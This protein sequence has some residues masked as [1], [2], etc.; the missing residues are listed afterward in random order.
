MAHKWLYIL[1]TH[2]FT[3]EDNPEE[4]LNLIKENFSKLHSNDTIQLVIIKN[5]FSKLRGVTNSESK[6]LGNSKTNISFCKTSL[7]IGEKNET[8]SVKISPLKKAFNYWQ[9]AFDYVLKEYKADNY[10]LYTYSHSDGF[11][12][13]LTEKCFVLNSSGNLLNKKNNIPA[14]QS[15]SF[16]R[17]FNFII[18]S[19][20]IK[21]FFKGF[22][23]NISFKKK[24]YE[25]LQPVKLH[26]KKWPVTNSSN[27]ILLHDLAEYLK[28]RATNFRLIFF[29]NCTALLLENLYHFAPICEVIVGSTGNISKNFEAA[30][31]IYTSILKDQEKKVS[32][33]E[34]KQNLTQLMT[35]QKNSTARLLMVELSNFKSIIESFTK[36]I[37][38]L[39][40]L[41]L[42][43]ESFK[44]FKKN[45]LQ[46]VPG[47]SISPITDDPDLQYYDMVELLTLF[48]NNN[49]D[50]I[51]SINKLEELCNMHIH[52]LHSP[53]FK[54]Y[55]S[56]LFPYQKRYSYLSHIRSLFRKPYSIFSEITNYSNLI[57]TLFLDKK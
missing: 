27:G 53:D 47:L 5:S 31:T 22:T 46:P 19:R 55:P 11:Q 44:A 49:A 10:I 14:H 29:H 42:K 48:A 25:K 16:K 41:Y 33:M 4:G 50:V 54:N 35:N 21:Y 39:N 7:L 6:I 1:F 38:E 37:S 30:Q 3:E 24:S 40:S 52:N 26:I 8:G 15:K 23:H 28:Q 13:G 36:I 56:I 17:Y 18:K 12:I 32:I 45:H 2:D 9:T 51:G 34:I 20:E 57:N 43:N